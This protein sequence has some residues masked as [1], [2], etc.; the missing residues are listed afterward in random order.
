MAL[1]REPLSGRYYASS[2]DLVHLARAWPSAIFFLPFA[3]SFVARA[4]RP[5]R[6]KLP[7]CD[8]R[9]FFSRGSAVFGTSPVASSK[10]RFATSWFASSLL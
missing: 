2:V 3:L 7:S 5:S 9:A 8:R 6:R 1:E 4:A 10:M